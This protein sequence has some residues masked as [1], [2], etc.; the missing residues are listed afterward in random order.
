MK[1]IACLLLFA[2]PALAVD[3]PVVYLRAPRPVDRRGNIPEVHTPVR[4]EPGTDLV[5]L[6]PDGTESVLVDAGE[7][8]CVLD[9]CPSLDAVWVFYSFIPDARRGDPDVI[10]VTVDGADIWKVNVATG[11]KVRL[12]FQEWTP[13]RGSINWSQQPKGPDAWQVWPTQEFL[14]HGIYNLGACPLPGGRVAFTSSRNGYTPVKSPFTHPCLQLWLMDDDG[15][16]AEQTGF[17]NLMGALHPTL[18]K[19]GRIMWS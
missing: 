4:V 1:T 11:E 7:F 17:L 3:Y 19:D 2:A 16:N 12:T 6:N 5:R 13:N 9:P 15:K 18:L 14:S 10:D 8:G